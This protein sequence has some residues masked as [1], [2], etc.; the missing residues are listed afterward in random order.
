MFQITLSGFLSAFVISAAP[1][2]GVAP[3]SIHEDA[4]TAA[5]RAELDLLHKSLEQVQ[6]ENQANK[7]ALT[8]NNQ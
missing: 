1:F 4:T 5:L 3:G 8:I 7:Q 2:G 6:V